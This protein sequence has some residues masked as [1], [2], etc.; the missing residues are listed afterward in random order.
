[1]VGAP[2][3]DHEPGCAVQPAVGVRALIQ[4]VLSAGAHLGT[5]I[6]RTPPAFDADRAVA[7]AELDDH[8]VNR[9]VQL[10]LENTKSLG[11][12]EPGLRVVPYHH[13]RIRVVYSQTFLARL[14]RHAA[15]IRFGLQ[16]AMRWCSMADRDFEV[17]D[18]H[19]P[20]F[21][22]TRSLTAQSCRSHAPQQ[23]YPPVL[24][25]GCWHFGGAAYQDYRHLAGADNRRRGGSEVC[26]LTAPMSNACWD[27]TVG[28]RRTLR[29][30]GHPARRIRPWPE[31]PSRSPRNRMAMDRGPSVRRF[32]RS[33]RQSKAN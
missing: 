24:T 22:S 3:H 33:V 23:S 2:T 30:Q 11:R 31:A 17:D 8:C 29:A 4:S 28:S 7:V 1:M 15:F 20:P 13:R 32:L 10:A 6:E 12:R 9:G 25:G 19:T 18:R 14:T 16:A 27:E 26:H 21:G 5:I